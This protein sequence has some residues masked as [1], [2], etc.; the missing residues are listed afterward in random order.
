MKGTDL[1]RLLEQK[2]SLQNS[3]ERKSKQNYCKLE[4]IAKRKKLTFTP[5]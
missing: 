5:G 4:I 3:N 1:Y 2:F